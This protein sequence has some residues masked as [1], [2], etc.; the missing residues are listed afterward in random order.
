MKMNLE[1]VPFSRR[2]SAI[3]FSHLDWNEL[4]T[5]PGLYLRCM[6]NG[7]SR[8]KIAKLEVLRDG[9]PI[10][11]KATATPD[12]LRLEARAGSVEVC[13]SAPTVVRFRGRGVGLRL[14]LDPGRFETANPSAGSTWTLDCFVNRVKYQAIPLQGRMTVDAPWAVA[15]CERILVD[16]LPDPDTGVFEAALDEHRSTWEP[17]PFTTSFEE[18]R[19]RVARDFEAWRRRMPAVP[20]RYRDAADLATYLNWSCI[21]S[22]GGHFTRPAMLMSKNSMG[23]VWS[24]DHCFNAMA[25]AAVDPAGA[26]DN[27]MLMFDNQ[28][29]FGAL[30]DSVN[31]RERVW[32]FCKPPIHGWALRDMMRRGAV[33]RARLREVYRPLSRWTDWWMKHRDDDRNGLPQYN[34]GNDSGWDNATVFDDG[35]PVEGPDLAAYLVIQMDVLAQI[36]RQ[37]GQPAAARAWTNKADRLLGRLVEELWRGD[38]FVTQ[39]MRDRTVAEPSDCLIN[40]MPIV[41]GDRLPAAIRTAMVAS[42]KRPGRLI[43]RHG[44]ATE[45]PRSPEYEPDGYWRGPI[46]APPTMIV[47]DGLNRCGERALAQDLARRFCDLCLRSGFAENFDALTGAGLRDRAYTWTSSVFL[48]LARDY[49]RPA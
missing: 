30:P 5:G 49:L 29:E 11:F 6:Y 25:L 18:C 32:N 28:D 48:L 39:R 38:Q 16:F 13:I 23:S 10:A 44:L 45:S 14:R 27:F 24:W 8:N 26:W 47:V 12:C 7:A 22:A 31:D 3:A 42:L 17:R 36:A 43:T 2:G 41:L 20:A 33:N 9:K 34:H 4:K 21:M 19:R 1:S 35:C 46:W 37:L 15:V 40:F